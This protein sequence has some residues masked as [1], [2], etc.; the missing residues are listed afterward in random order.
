MSI[1]EANRL[2]GGDRLLVFSLHHNDEEDAAFVS[3]AEPAHSPIPDKIAKSHRLAKPKELCLNVHGL[4][5]HTPMARLERTVNLAFHESSA[6]ALL[7]ANQLSG[8]L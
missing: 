1:P 6:A 8:S 2:R 4:R 3:A 5:P 7:N